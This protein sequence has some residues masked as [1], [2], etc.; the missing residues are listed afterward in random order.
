MTVREW[1]RLQRGELHR[2][3]SLLAGDL[4]TLVVRVIT[5][6]D[7]DLVERLGTHR[8][9]FDWAPW[10]RRQAL[11]DRIRGSL[12]DAM[13]ELDREMARRAAVEKMHPEWLARRH[14]ELPDP[15]REP[16]PRISWS[17]FHAP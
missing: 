17:G 14:P 10:E 5:G 9:I 3:D 8:L 16:Y 11:L 2:T 15:R 13:R 4:D 7:L 6:Q 1:F 12:V